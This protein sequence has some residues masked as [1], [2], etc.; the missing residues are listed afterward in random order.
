MGIKK[1][2]TTKKKSNQT[3]KRKRDEISKR[4]ANPADENKIHDIPTVRYIFGNR[5]C[6]NVAF[7]EDVYCNF[8][9]YDVALI[10]ALFKAQE[11]KHQTQDFNE[12]LI[13]NVGK[14]DDHDCDIA[15]FEYYDTTDNKTKLY[16]N[17]RKAVSITLSQKQSN[18][19]FFSKCANY[20]AFTTK[21][22]KACFEFDDYRVYKCKES[23]SKQAGKFSYR[24]ISSTLLKPTC[25]S[26]CG[27]ILMNPINRF[28]IIDVIFDIEMY[29]ELKDIPNIDLQQRKIDD[30]EN[31]DKPI[32]LTEIPII[33]DNRYDKDDHITACIGDLTNDQSVF[34]SQVNHNN[35]VI[36]SIP[37]SPPQTTQP[38]ANP[39]PAQPC[40]EHNNEQYNLLPALSSKK[41][42]LD[43]VLLDMK[44]CSY[45]EEFRQEATSFNNYYDD[46]L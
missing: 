8:K 37:D 7:V 22:I 26:T 12:S 5:I 38:S 21:P 32:T 33:N 11:Q 36:M 1:K 18:V 20:S 6:N 17:R 27:W 2:S 24:T 14:D 46:R 45:E 30:G 4:E 29:N 28:E 40:E 41:P 42:L 23:N 15:L 10:R 31:T 9:P 39:S 16:Q 3:N 44:W 13:N 35:Q 34:E 25:E 43:E 19:Y